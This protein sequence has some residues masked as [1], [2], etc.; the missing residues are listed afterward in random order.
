P[1]SRTQRFFL[2]AEVCLILPIKIEGVLAA[3]NQCNSV[4]E[5]TCTFTAV[6]FSVLIITQRRYSK[7]CNSAAEKFFKGKGSQLTMTMPVIMVHGGAW[8]IPEKLVEASRA[9]THAAA[10]A[11][12]AVLMRGGSAIDAVPASILVLENDPTFDAGTGSVLTRNGEVEMDSVIMDGKTLATGAVACVHNI[13]NP[14]DLARRHGEVPDPDACE[15]D[16]V[17]APGL[18]L[19]IVIVA[20]LPVQKRVVVIKNPDL[21]RVTTPHILLVSKGANQ[22][23]DEVGIK[24]VTT[25]SLVS[26]E[27]RREFEDYHANYGSAVQDLFCHR[28]THHHETV[29]AVALDADGNLAYAT[30]TGGI[31]CK[32]PGRVGDSPIIGAGGYADNDVGTV[33][34]TGHGES[35]SKV[36]LAHLIVS[37]MRNGKAPQEAADKALEKM[38]A[39]VNG[40]G[41]VIVLSNSGEPVTSFTTE[42]MSWA[43]IKDGVLHSGINPDEDI[44]E[45]V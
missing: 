16:C 14:I 11:G 31:S 38:A 20:T 6:F 5:T 39:R 27:A 9:G 15:R 17:Y 18:D 8:T 33:S 4:S 1:A 41:G 7:T 23:A 21:S 22:F 32:R 2:C 29:G 45:D 12:Y 26:E 3:T 25:E 19:V 37:D 40:Y 43:W 36:V 42:S 35:I 34:C 30:S 24:R 13:K 10:R 28:G 44:T